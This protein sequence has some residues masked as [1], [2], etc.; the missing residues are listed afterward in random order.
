MTLPS[1]V[2][3]R[4][5]QSFVELGASGIPARRMVL[6]DAAGNALWPPAAALADGAANP[7]TPLVGGAQLGLNAGGTWDR[8]RAN[9]EGTLLASAARTALAQA[10][11]QTNYNGRGV[12]LFL[13]VTAASG[14]GGLSVRLQAVDPL[15]GTAA[16][17]NGGPTLVTATGL[18][19]YEFYPGGLSAAPS[20]SAGFV[21]QRVSC[22]LPR[23]WSAVVNVGDASSYTYSLGYAVVL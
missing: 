4:E 12:L 20:T 18:Y 5:Y 3:D 10:P 11:V 21:V 23:S 7:T 2:M 16:L 13:N 14:T 1:H 6:Y 9:L 8:W 15:S 19:A 17:A 22:A